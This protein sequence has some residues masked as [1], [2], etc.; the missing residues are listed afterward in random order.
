[1]HRNIAILVA[2]LVGY[3]WYAASKLRLNALQQKAVNAML[4]IVGVQFLLGVFTL[5][6][7]VPVW[8]G[9]LHQIG[10]FFLF[11]AALFFIHST[12]RSNIKV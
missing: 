5:L 3:V 11:S 4:L 1:M 8:L 6:Y 7:A 9:V 2:I 10:A 12:Q